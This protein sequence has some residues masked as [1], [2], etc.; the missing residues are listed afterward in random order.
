MLRVGK[1]GASPIEIMIKDP[2]ANYVV[3]KVINVAD[4][5]QRKE[6]MRHIQAQATQLKRFTYGKHILSHVDL[7]PAGEQ[8]LQ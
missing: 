6:V 7:M 8:S 2:Y 1:S 3:Q 5:Q 4:V